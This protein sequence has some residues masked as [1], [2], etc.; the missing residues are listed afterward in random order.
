MEWM[1]MRQRA[2]A[3]LRLGDRDAVALG[4]GRKRSC[5]V[6]IVHA[7]AGD[8]ERL[9]SRSDQ[10]C[11]ICQFARIGR[12]AALAPDALREEALRIREGLGLRI[13]A[14]CE[15]DRA[16]CGGISEDAHGPRQGREYLLGPGNA[17]AEAFA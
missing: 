15:R 17:E 2:L 11:S 9:A 7:A 6:G 1:I 16:T 5:G 3:G 14:Q 8:D 10:A 12:R 13:L 4:A